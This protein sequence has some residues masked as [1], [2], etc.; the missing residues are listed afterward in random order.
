[1]IEHLKLHRPVRPVAAI[2]HQVRIRL[3]DEL[4]GGVLSIEHGHWLHDEWSAIFSN[5]GDFTD[6]NG[7]VYSNIEWSM[8]DEE[9][10]IAEEMSGYSRYSAHEFVTEAYTEL[11]LYDGDY[12][13]WSDEAKRMYHRLYGILPDGRSTQSHESSAPVCIL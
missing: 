5:D 10:N 7:G 11:V 8:P 12:G 9:F 3:G 1:M 2:E 4:V 6:R 13:H